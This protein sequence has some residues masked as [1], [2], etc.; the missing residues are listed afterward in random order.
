MIPTRLI[1]RA[2]YYTG[3]ILHRTFTPDEVLKAEHERDEI[4]K[5]LRGS[6]SPIYWIA[7]IVISALVQCK[8]G[9][10]ERTLGAGILGFVVGGLAVNAY[11]DTHHINLLSDESREILYPA[12]QMPTAQEKKKK[13]FQ[14][15]YAISMVL[16]AP[17]VWH[18]WGPEFTEANANAVF[19]FFFKDAIAAMFLPIIAFSIIGAVLQLL[20][21]RFQRVPDIIPR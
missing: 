15:A 17:A 13:R 20:K 7:V 2:L 14:L 10:W 11:I 12:R 1:A 6:L 19:F 18:L 4:C 5:S 8:W 9:D 3:D 16:C 21:R